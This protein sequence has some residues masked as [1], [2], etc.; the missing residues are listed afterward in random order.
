MKWWGC[1]RSGDRRRLWPGRAHTH[2]HTPPA[3]GRTCKLWPCMRGGRRVQI[4]ESAGA[5]DRSAGAPAFASPASRPAQ[6]LRVCGCVTEAAP[7]P[8]SPLPA[9]NPFPP[10]ASVLHVGLGQRG[11]GGRLG[12]GRNVSGHALERAARRLAHPGQLQLKRFLAL[13]HRVQAE[14]MVAGGGG[15]GCGSG[16]GRARGRGACGRGKEPKTAGVRAQPP[17]LRPPL[18]PLPLNPPAPFSRTFWRPPPR[19]R[20]M[21]AR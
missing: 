3:G 6:P 12:G 16:V 15:G 7:A 5:A 9:S 20:R 2:A 18:P 19:P 1:A 10:P 13:V 21:S 4:E 11:L 17:P 14:R 8:R